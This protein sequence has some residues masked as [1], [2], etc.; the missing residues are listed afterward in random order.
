MSQQFVCANI[1]SMSDH[2]WL[3]LRASQ[4][5]NHLLSLQ[6]VMNIIYQMICNQI[7]NLYIQIQRSWIQYVHLQSI[8]SYHYC[9]LLMNL[10][11]MLVIDLTI[12]GH[13]NSKKIFR[14]YY[15]FLFNFLFYNDYWSNIWLFSNYFD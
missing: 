11:I 12:I 10:F 9:S 13:F 4:A 8:N 6:H 14:F 3:S 15:F 2:N 1:R 7:H 5:A